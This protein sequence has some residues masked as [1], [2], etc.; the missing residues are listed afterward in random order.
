MKT[1]IEI[2]SED[3]NELIAFTGAKSK[4]EAVNQAIKAYNKQ[5]RMARLA[6]KLGTFENFMNSNELAKMRDD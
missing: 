1:T 3:L 2:P 6:K 5:Q 4:K